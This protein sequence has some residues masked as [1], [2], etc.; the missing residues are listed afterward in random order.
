MGKSIWI[1][2]FGVTLLTIA[3]GTFFGQMYNGDCLYIFKIVLEK[4]NDFFTWIKQLF[5]YLFS[6]FGGIGDWI[7]MPGTP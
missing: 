3:F 1:A 5:T 4:I 2:F 6:A 7:D